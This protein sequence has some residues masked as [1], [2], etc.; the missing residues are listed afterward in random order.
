MAADPVSPDVAP[1][2]ASLPPLDPVERKYSKK[3]PSIW[4]ATSL[5]ANVGPWNSSWFVVVVVEGD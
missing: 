1:S 4:S 2:T 3:L 5:K